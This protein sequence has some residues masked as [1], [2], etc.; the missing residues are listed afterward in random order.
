M[1]HRNTPDFTHKIAHL[2]LDVNQEEAT[3]LNGIKIV[4]DAINRHVYD[5]NMCISGCGALDEMVRK[6]KYFHRARLFYN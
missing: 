6:S 2:K 4:L 3:R 1:V 5:A